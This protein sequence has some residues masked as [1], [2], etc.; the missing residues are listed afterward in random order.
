[1]CHQASIECCLLNSVEMIDVFPLW[2]NFNEWIFI[3]QILDHKFLVEFGPCK[4]G[5]YKKTTYQET[6]LFDIISYTDAL[7]HA[8]MAGDKVSDCK[9]EIVLNCIL[10][11]HCY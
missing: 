6:F 9:L 10:K 11:E 8:V 5:D 3:F 2:K 7:R 1:M 4:H